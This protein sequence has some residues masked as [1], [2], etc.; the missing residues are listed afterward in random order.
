MKFFTL[1]DI[2]R[3]AASS[4]TSFQSAERILKESARAH[5]SAKTYDIFLS[6]SF[7][8]AELV[9]GVKKALEQEGYTVYVDWVDDPHLDRSNVTKE[10]AQ[11][12]KNRMHTCKG[13]VY[14]TSKNS[15]HSKWMPWELGYFDGHKPGQ[16]SILPLVDSETDD[17][18]G[19]E[20]L[21]LYPV[22]GKN[23]P[24]YLTSYPP[25]GLQIYDG[26]QT[27]AFSLRAA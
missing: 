27:R 15:K 9:L 20:Y 5:T 21:S 3:T 1:N 12:I 19:Q 13:L 24:S 6:H 8:D 7:S 22:L 11:H 2:R 25:R 23:N 18:K 26:Q 17:F 10:T 14:A 16:V 4:V